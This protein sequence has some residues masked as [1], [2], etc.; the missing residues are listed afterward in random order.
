MGNVSSA[1]GRPT[2]WLLFW[3]VVILLT[4]LH[5]TT[6]RITEGQED[7]LTGTRKANVEM[8]YNLHQHA[9]F[10]QSWEE[11]RARAFSAYRPPAYP[12][13][14]ALGMFVVGDLDTWDLGRI[15]KDASRALSPLYT[16]QKLTLLLT[17]YL[18]MYAVWCTTRSRWICL[19]PFPFIC[20]TPLFLIDHRSI[21]NKYTNLFY[22]TPFATLLITALGLSLL[23]AF[24]KKR[25]WQFALSGCLAGVLALTRATFLYYIFLGA[26]VLIVWLWRRPDQRRV[27][28]PRAACCVAVALVIAFGWMARNQ[29]HFGR[30]FI[31]ERGGYQL[32]VRAQMLDMNTSL[33]FASFLYWNNSRFLEHTVLPRVLD[34]ELRRQIDRKLNHKSWTSY[35]WTAKRDW[36]RYQKQYESSVVADRVLLRESMAAILKHPIKHL[37]ISIPLSHRGM[38]VAKPYW[39][40]WLL[41]ASFFGVA[42]WA[43]WRGQSSRLAMLSP[44]VFCF[45]FNT[46]VINNLSRYNVLLIPLLYVAAAI[47]LHHGI[48]IVA[49]GKVAGIGRR[50][51]PTDTSCSSRARLSTA[52]S[53]SSSSPR[54]PPLR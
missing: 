30:F 42:G 49:G 36:L 37:L 23:I 10:S 43:L 21:L 31:A 2:E 27:L 29:Y 53:I 4:G 48:G 35:K 34:D 16:I 52:G 39:L 47:V 5:A 19:L 6:F 40:N 46:A 26:L 3:G 33:Y 15:T 32:A 41:F 8:A 14:L 18:A 38:C 13:F 1:P 11:P 54:R 22:P 45:G 25:Y 12:T 7:R 51:R 24:E 50:Y 44:A 17:A 9:V 20:H 28:A